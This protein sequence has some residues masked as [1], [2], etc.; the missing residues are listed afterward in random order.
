MLVEF[1]MDGLIGTLEG[2]GWKVEDMALAGSSQ[3]PVAPP[4]AGSK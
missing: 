3:E 2:M 4:R 1:A